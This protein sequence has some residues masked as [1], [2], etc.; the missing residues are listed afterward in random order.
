M[1]SQPLSINKLPFAKQ[2]GNSE[3]TLVGID[4]TIDMKGSSSVPTISE[5]QD[6]GQLP[7]D[8]GS[9]DKAQTLL[10]ELIKEGDHCATD[11]Q[12]LQISKK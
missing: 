9:A 8:I 1:V 11:K 4:T 7:L 3:D 12:L 10:I 6:T 5:N 2:V